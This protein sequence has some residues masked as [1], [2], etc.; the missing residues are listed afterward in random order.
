MSI[1]SHLKHRGF[2][3]VAGAAMLAGLTS[4]TAVSAAP[5]VPAN[6][7]APRAAAAPSH[8]RLIRVDEDDEGFGMGGLIGGLALGALAGGALSGGYYGPAYGPS[9]Y[10][11]PGPVYYRRCY[12]ARRHLWTRWGWR[13]RLVRICN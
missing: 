6:P 5:I 8:G 1:F 3:V 9:Y 12:L 7:I 2:A 4:A 10:Y 11:G 13:W